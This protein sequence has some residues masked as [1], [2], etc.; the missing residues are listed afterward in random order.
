MKALQGGKAQNE[1]I[2]AHTI[3]VLLR[4]GMLPHAYVYPA[5]MRAT[6]DLRRRRCPLVRQRAELLAHIQNTNSQY[7]LPE[8]GKKLADKANRAG[9]EEHFPDPR[10]RKTIAV[11]VS[12]SAHYDK[13]LG[14]VELYLTRSAKAPDVQTFARL[15]S[16][17][18]IG[19]ILALV[20]LYEIQDS[21]RFPRVQAFVSYCRLVKGAKESGGKRRGTAGKKLGTVPLRW[22]F[23]EAAVLFLRQNQLGKAYFTKLE[24]QHGK[25]TA[26]TV[27]AHKLA[28]AVY[29][30]LTREQAFDL[31]RFVTA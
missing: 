19:Q 28:R 26:L 9:V 6:R 21:A 10:V 11:E 4:G 29:Y 18:G 24:H 27:L 1:K 2:D 17:P 5:E 22:A 14:E 13:L 31:Q 3:A 30:L 23:A 16:V 25:A 7:T 15:H 20:L 12:L 8:L